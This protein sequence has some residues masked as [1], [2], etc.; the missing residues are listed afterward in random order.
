LT[1]LDELNPIP[2]PREEVEQKD[3]KIRKYE[4]G[5]D[6][7]IGASLREGLRRLSLPPIIP[8]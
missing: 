6:A 8:S 7:V 2:R 4:D 1:W 3:Q 5:S